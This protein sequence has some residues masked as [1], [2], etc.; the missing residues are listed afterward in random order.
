MVKGSRLYG[1][2]LSN[3]F[4]IIGRLNIPGGFEVNA[5]ALGKENFERALTG[6]EIL[7]IYQITF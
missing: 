7:I 2:N 5:T 3:E 1:G 6:K 4:V